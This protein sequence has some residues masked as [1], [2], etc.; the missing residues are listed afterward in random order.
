MNVLFFVIV[1]LVASLLIGLLILCKRFLVKRC[2]NPVAN[3]IL[4]LERKL[5]FNSILRATLESYFLLAVQMWYAWRGAHVTHSTLSLINFF[6]VL[7]MTA[8]CLIFPFFVHKLLNGKKSK[9]KS[10]EFS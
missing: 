3:L 1:L 6:T 5:M 10:A 7:A 4:S 2:C 8:Y 9:L